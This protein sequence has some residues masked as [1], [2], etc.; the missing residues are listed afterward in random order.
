MQVI[1]EI[2]IKDNKVVRLEGTTTTLYNENPV[3]MAKSLKEVGVEALL[4]RDLNV[5]KIGA[6]PNSKIIS[7]IKSETGMFMYL[8]GSY[9]TLSSIELSFSV[10]ADVVVLGTV[11]YQEPNLV[12]EACEKFSDKIGVSISLRQGRVTIP[13]WT[14]VAN[15]NGY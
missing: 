13:G 3:I 12:K 4:V 8:T 14:V 11:A 6:S 7:N 2:Y 1:P 9:V 10:G 5:P 15:K